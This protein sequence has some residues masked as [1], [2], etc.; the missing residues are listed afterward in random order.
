LIIA[1]RSQRAGP[2]LACSVSLPANSLASRILT[3][4]RCFSP[5][6]GQLLIAAT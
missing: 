5:P 2:K 6:H 4:Q 3:R 1:F